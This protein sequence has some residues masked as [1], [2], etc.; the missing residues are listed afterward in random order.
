MGAH[1]QSWT[2]AI[3]AASWSDHSN[4]LT[5]GVLQYA[6]EQPDIELA[7]LRFFES[8]YDKPSEPPPWVGKPID[9]VV[10]SIGFTSWEPEWLMSGGVPL[11]NVSADLVGSAIPN[12]HTSFSS[13]AKLAADH[14]ID[15]GFERF[16]YVGYDRGGSPR[17]R[18]AF[19]DELRERG[20]D[21]IR[22]DLPLPSETTGE[23]PDAIDGKLLRQIKRW[24][25]P[26]GVLAL[27]DR[28]AR[29]VCRACDELGLSIPEEIGVLGVDD[30]KV[31]RLG[32]P[33]LSSIRVPSEALGYRAVKMLHQLL[34]G[35]RLSNR[36]VV[37]PAKEVVVRQSTARHRADT[38]DI[39]R[40]IRLIR[41]NAC[42]G[43][44]VD[45]VMETLPISRPTFEKRF[46]ERVG[47]TPGQEIQRVRLERAKELLST[48]G[49]SITQ[50]ASMVGYGRVSVFSDF[51]RRQT[52]DSP[53]HFRDEH[54]IRA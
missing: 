4:R 10:S 29:L 20:H 13:V 47:H 14:L 37:L 3:Y 49:L 51:F 28:V 7:D 24:P 33:T 31:A 50:I 23:S 42:L 32:N 2:I 27:N 44:R 15:T 52:G 5:D 6:S 17:R 8:S 26:I 12:V 46:S 21:L 39:E 9:A 40:A 54:R 34:R 11:V 30:S 45:D 35:K 19:G 22:F 16:A 41:D 43:I 48:T 38:D 53:K 1:T 18:E 36:N 25:K